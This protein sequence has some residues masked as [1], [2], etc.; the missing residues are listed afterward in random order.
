M[1]KNVDVAAGV[2]IEASYYSTT[3]VGKRG[4]PKRP[5][6]FIVVERKRE[7]SR[8]KR[9]GELRE[10]KEECENECDCVCEKTSQSANTLKFPRPANF[11]F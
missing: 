3:V 2:I 6:V 10:E 1:S 4:T 5:I 9:V 8:A 7:S 11:F